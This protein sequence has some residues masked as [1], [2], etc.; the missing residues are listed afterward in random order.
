VPVRN[1]GG[2]LVVEL[3]GGD[4]LAPTAFL[5]GP[6]SRVFSVELVPSEIDALV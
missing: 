1:P 6:A 5:C 2:T 4:P 3:E